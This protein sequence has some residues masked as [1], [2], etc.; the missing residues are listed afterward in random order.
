MKVKYK[1]GVVPYINV[2]PLVWGI[3]NL[4]DEIET[5]NAT[6]R[7][8]SNLLKDGKIDIGILPTFEY[9]TTNIYDYVPGICI[10]SNGAVKS[11]VLH[12]KVSLKKTKR[13]LL[14]RSSKTSIALLKILLRER[15]IEPEFCISE[16]P[17]IEYSELP[18]EYDAYLTIGD[19]AMQLNGRYQQSYDL[20]ELWKNLTGLPFVFALWAY[21][22]SSDVE[23]LCEILKSC[24]RE[25]LKNIT[26]VAE[27]AA[28]KTGLSFETCQKYFTK[29]IDYDL[30][31]NKLSA[32]KVFKDLINKHNIYV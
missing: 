14:D 19:V 12:S 21:K 7:Q 29:I 32:M 31:D 1:I 13:I 25:G 11:V 17:L 28:R 3:E 10:S 27:K 30:D 9:L 4:T 26:C 15:H 22:K 23:R 5:I 2:M 8:I 18:K 6:P 16:K 24:K 20:G